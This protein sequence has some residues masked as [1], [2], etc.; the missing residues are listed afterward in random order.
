VALTLP[1]P[2]DGLAIVKQ[3]KELD[4]NPKFN[5][6]IR[7]ADGLSWGENLG[8]DGDF[9]M[10]M[11]GWNPDVKFPGAA[12]FVQKHQAKYGKPAQATTGPAYAAI[13]VLA[14][15]IERAATL[16][17]DGIRDAIAATDMPTVVGSV[18][19]NPDGTGQ[20]ITVINQWQG[21]KQVLIWPKDQAVAA[22]Q[23]PAKAFK[24]R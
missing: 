6:F 4:V 16:D 15:A 19:F 10:N 8:K 9:A 3:M 13:Q 21:G 24:E 22:I 20:V 7:A 23:Y 2:P 5:L 18:K 17:R 14:N 11:P 12:D 1:S